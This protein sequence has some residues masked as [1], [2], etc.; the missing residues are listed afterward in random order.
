[1]LCCLLA[2]AFADERS[3]QS[4]QHGH[5]PPHG[6]QI[7]KGHHDKHAIVHQQP[8][9]APQDVHNPYHGKEKYHVAAVHPAH[10]PSYRAPAVVY[11]PQSPAPPPKIFY[12]PAPPQKVVYKPSKPAYHLAPKVPAHKPEPAYNTPAHYSY[13]YAVNDDYTKN[14]FSANEA[15][16]GYDTNGEYRVVLPDGRTQVVKYNVADSYSGYI[17]EVSYEGKASYVHPE[18]HAKATPS[19]HS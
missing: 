17:A 4:I 16:D 6:H 2:V 7:I 12:K 3:H 15:R 9:T 19:Y 18:P 1:M 10:G 8:H 13:E 5:A 11:K 14:Y